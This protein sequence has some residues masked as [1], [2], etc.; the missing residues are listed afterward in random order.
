M[1][2][3]VR[4]GADMWRML[5]ASF[6]DVAKVNDLMRHEERAQLWAGFMGAA[7][8]AMARDLGISDAKLILEHGI[9]KALDDGIAED[10]RKGQH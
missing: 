8:G 5:D 3:P 1:P 6:Q 9:A 10:L 7:F 2:K 4:I